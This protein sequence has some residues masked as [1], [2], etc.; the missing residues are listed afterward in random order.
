M[1]EKTLDS[2]GIVGEATLDLIVESFEEQIQELVERLTESQMPEGPVVLHGKCYEEMPS[3]E[4][5]N[6]D[7]DPYWDC[8]C[9]DCNLVG[10]GAWDTWAWKNYDHEHKFTKAAAADRRW[11]GSSTNSS[12]RGTRHR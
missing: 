3:F 12:R 1:N 6:Y 7:T 8:D 2:Y 11:R 9:K 5:F 10:D 4:D